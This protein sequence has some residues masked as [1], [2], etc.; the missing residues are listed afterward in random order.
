VTALTELRCGCT[1]HG[2]V[3]DG[4]LTVKCHQC[5][6]AAGRPVYHRWNTTTALWT[7]LDRERFR[8]RARNGGR[9]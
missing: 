3:Q 7:F 8:P 4:I 1:L 6:S 5:S 2:I 9:G